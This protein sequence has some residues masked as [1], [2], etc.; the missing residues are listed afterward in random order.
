[1]TSH[2]LLSCAACKGS[3]HAGPVQA[4]FHLAQP[5]PTTA[6]RRTP[7]SA[8]MPIMRHLLHPRMVAL[9][10][11]VGQMQQMWMDLRKASRLPRDD[12]HVCAPWCRQ[13]RPLCRGIRARVIEHRLPSLCP[14]WVVSRGRRTLTPCYLI[15]L[16]AHQQHRPDNLMSPRLHW[17]N[18]QRKVLKRV[19]SHKRR[20]Q[21]PRC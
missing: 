8:H 21:R 17:K 7:Q 4:H 11:M 2:L 9:S 16:F 18:L 19:R 1:M 3:A 15:P 14:S 12:Q 6:I 10:V 5:W 20:L 13:S